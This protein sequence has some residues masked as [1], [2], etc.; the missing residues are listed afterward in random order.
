MLVLVPPS[1]LH[2]KAGLPQPCD[3]LPDNTPHNTS[4]KHLWVTILVF[5]IKHVAWNKKDFA[6][7]CCRGNASF[8]NRLWWQIFFLSY[9]K[10]GLLSKKLNTSQIPK[11]KKELL[12]LLMTYP[13]RMKLA[14]MKYANLFPSERTQD[15]KVNWQMV[16]E[17]MTEIL[18]HHFPVRMC[19]KV[20]LSFVSS[21]WTTGMKTGVGVEEPLKKQ[22]NKNTQRKQWWVILT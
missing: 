18:E 14:C 3:M 20:S 13:L 22:T 1:M 7:T 10:Y 11:K 2:F 4:I 19:S 21:S 8:F 16:A 15:T 9:W 5:G 17:R 6:V 12:L